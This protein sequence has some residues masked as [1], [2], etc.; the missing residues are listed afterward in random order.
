MYLFYFLLCKL[1]ES[2]GFVKIFDFQFL[3]DLHILGS[4]DHDLTISEKCLSS[5]LSVRSFVCLSVCVHRTKI[6]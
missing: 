4:P 5:C 1:E 3:M 2:I 6:L